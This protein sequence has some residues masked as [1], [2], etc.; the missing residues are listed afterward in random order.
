[1]NFFQVIV[2][3]FTRIWDML[4]NSLEILTYAITIVFTSLEGMKMITMIMPAVIGSGVLVC[5]AV[6]VVRFLLLK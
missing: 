6:L 4:S 5:I 1:M 2:D 3:F